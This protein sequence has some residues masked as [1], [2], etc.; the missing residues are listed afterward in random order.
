MIVL[1]AEDTKTTYARHHEIHPSM[2][3]IKVQDVAIALLHSIEKAAGLSAHPKAI[4][5]S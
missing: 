1:R 5:R 3:E 2:K 4:S